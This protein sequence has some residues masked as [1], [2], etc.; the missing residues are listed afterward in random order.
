MVPL[1]IVWAI[2]AYGGMVFMKTK[3]ADE[4]GFPVVFLKKFL[5][6]IYINKHALRHA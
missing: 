4:V 2:S 1:L 3:R 5:K 6:K